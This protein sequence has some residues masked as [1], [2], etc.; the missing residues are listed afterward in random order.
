M[1]NWIDLTTNEQLDQIVADSAAKPIVIFKHSTRCS[2]SSMAQRRLENLSH[3]GPAVFYYLDLIRYRP[4]SNQI[5]EDFHVHHESPQI[6]IIRNGE[7]VYEESHNGIV[8][9]DIEAE[10]AGM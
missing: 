4:L 1:T 6:L 3:T 2:I 7:C 8:A 5:A 10:L 9:K